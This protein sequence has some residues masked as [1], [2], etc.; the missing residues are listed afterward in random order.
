MSMRVVH[1]THYADLYGA[2][3]SLLTLIDGERS[4]HGVEPFV[5]MARGGALEQELDARGIA[6]AVIPFPLWMHRRHYEGGP[7]HR[8]KQWF[9]HTR[10]TRRRMREARGATAAIVAQ[11]RQWSVDLVHVNSAVIGLGGAVAQALDLP[12]VW[13]V[14]ELV[15]GHYRFHVDGGRQRFGR[16][17]A[18]TDAVIAVSKAVSADVQEHAR[19]RAQVQLVYNGV[20][21]RSAFDG[22]AAHTADRWADKGTFRFVLV[23]LIHPDKGQERAVKAFAEVHRRHP[24][25]RMLLAGDGRVAELERVMAQCG[26]GAAVER[27]PFVQDPLALFL[28]SHAALSLAHHEAFGRTTAEAMATGIPVIGLNDGATPELITD[29]VSGRLI[30]GSHTALVN[31]MED[32]LGD[33]ER[34]AR[35]GLAAREQAGGRWLAERMVEEVVTVFRSVTRSRTHAR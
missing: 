7:H 9:G 31:A 26:V 34:A 8:L 21:D 15:E 5:I 27:S 3:R 2:G 24:H 11:C 4:A 10:D 22:L 12:W 17:L 16:E 20:L 33:P 32:L 30:D 28:R 6:H 1:L 35:M 13:H 18:R 25:A 29:G 19:G 14:R 23:G